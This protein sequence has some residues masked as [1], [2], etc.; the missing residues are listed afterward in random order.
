MGKARCEDIE[1]MMEGVDEADEVYTT[2][3]DYLGYDSYGGTINIVVSSNHWRL[4][5]KVLKKVL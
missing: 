5:A 2:A 1:Q 3:V 4:M